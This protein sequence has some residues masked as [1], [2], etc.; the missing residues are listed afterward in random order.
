MKKYLRSLAVLGALL[1]PIV[2]LAVASPPASAATDLGNCQ[3]HDYT[4]Y[5]VGGG[6]YLAHGAID[7]CPKNEVL[8]IEVCMT[9]LLSNGWNVIGSSCYTEY[10]PSAR[11]INST[12]TPVFLVHGRWY[13][14]ITWGYANGNSKWFQ[15]GPGVLG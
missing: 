4:P 1:T 15:I 7:S 10:Y 5:S 8:E 9:Q 3:L 2:A 13:E 12:S 11:G 14:S 6:S